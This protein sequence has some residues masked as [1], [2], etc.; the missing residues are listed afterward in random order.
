MAEQEYQHIVRV[1]NTDLKGS[2]HTMYALTKIKGVGYTFANAVCTAAGVSKTTKVG[3]LPQSDIHKL[4]DVLQKPAS[5]GIPEWMFNRQRDFMTGE[6][7]H[8]L[9]NDLAFTKDQDLKRMKRLKSYRGIR[10]IFG[11]PVRGQRTRSNFRKN[12]GKVQ[13]VKRKK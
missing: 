10:H 3:N 4:N 8:I 13:G 6:D 9:T 2:K 12:K 5:F 7:K 1:A 11:K